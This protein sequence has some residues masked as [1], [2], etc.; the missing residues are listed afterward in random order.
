[1]NHT[2]GER[3]GDTLLQY[4]AEVLRSVVAAEEDEPFAAPQVA[5]L[6]GDTFAVLLPAIGAPEVAATVADRI[7]EG[8]SVPVPIGDREVSISASVGSAVHPSDGINAESLL[9]NAELAL[10]H[11]KGPSGRQESFRRSMSV[12][13]L[14]RFTLASDLRRAVEPGELR[15][16]YQPRIRASDG[17]TLGAEA[18]V[19]WDHPTLGSVSPAEF[20]PIAEQAGLIGRIGSFVLRTACREFHALRD[21][22]PEARVSVNV[23]SWQ[24][25]QTDIWETVTSCLRE[26]GLPAA[27][28]ELEITESLMIDD[29]NDPDAAL[30]D[31]KGI[32]IEIALDDF[33]TGYTSLS[34]VSRFPVD[35]IKLDRALTREAGEDPK[36]DRV[37]RAIV[38]LAHELDM[39][40]VGERVDS[41]AQARAVREIG[42]DEIQGFLIAG[43]LEMPALR[44]RLL[45]ESTSTRAAEPDLEP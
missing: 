15:V 26:T 25:A 1:V 14:R 24:L 22:A 42:V 35:V 18:L 40:V 7:L 38:H 13:A 6:H 44:E 34:Y 28:L 45:S 2:A 39:R 9:Q 5:R 23:S 19:R 36:A 41:E 27:A 43:A 37:A 17:R 8:V 29:D 31:L 30:R 20:I 11:A 3:G 32:G 33:G 4:V 12:N 21:V 10:L 16:V